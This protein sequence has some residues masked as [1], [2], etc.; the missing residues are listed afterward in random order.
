MTADEARVLE[1]F[2]WN[3]NEAVLHCDETVSRAV[4]RGILRPLIKHV[5]TRSSCQSRDWHG[6]VGTT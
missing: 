3:K 5:Y 6:R 1:A 2:K 4:S